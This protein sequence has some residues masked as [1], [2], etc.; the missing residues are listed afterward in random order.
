MRMDVQVPSNQPETLKAMEESFYSNYMDKVATL[1]TFL[2]NIEDIERGTST[3]TDET[4]TDTPSMFKLRNELFE[5]DSHQ[6]VMFADDNFRFVQASAGFYKE[7]LDWMDRNPD[8]GFVS[9]VGAFGS[10]YHKDQLHRS[11]ACIFETSRGLIFRRGLHLFPATWESLTGGLEDLVAVYY[12][13]E[14]GGL[15]GKRF[16]C[17]TKHPVSNRAFR[18][19]GESYIHRPDIWKANAIRFIQERYDDPTWDLPSNRAVKKRLPF[20]LTQRR[21]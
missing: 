1:S 7:V 9:C 20:G 16:M 8:I 3:L 5:C 19:S 11:K 10:V 12:S 15:P 4:V 14:K 21:V 13:M 6:Y 18:E 17:P 2:N